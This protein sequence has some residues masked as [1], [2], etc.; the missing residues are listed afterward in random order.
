VLY[1]FEPLVTPS[2]RQDG[3]EGLGMG[4]RAEQR[5]PSIREG[6]AVTA[7]AFGGHAASSEN[8]GDINDRRAPRFL[9]PLSH[10]ARPLALSSLRMQAARELRE[11]GEG[12]KGQRRPASI[13]QLMVLAGPPHLSTPLLSAHQPL[14]NPSAP[15]AT[16]FTH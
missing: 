10:T 13:L 14:S 2:P 12:D 1:D 9:L 8:E 3:G 7:R 5:G 16:S 4:T 6:G 11:A 15:T